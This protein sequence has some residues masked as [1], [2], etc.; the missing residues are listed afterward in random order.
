MAQ[1]YKMI[2]DAHVRVGEKTVCYIQALKDFG[3]VKSGDIGGAIETESNLS[4]DGD[5]WVYHNAKVYGYGRVSGNAKI[6]DTAEVLDYA[7]VAGDAI[8]AGN[9]KVFQRALVFDKALIDG[10]S[11][12][13][14]AAQVFGNARVIGFSRVHEDAWVYGDVLVDGYSNITRKTTI[15]PITLLGLEY[16]V[17]IM[18][19]DISIDCQTRSFDEWR[20][21]TREEAFALNGKHSLKFFNE[22]F[23]TFEF[24]VQKYRKN[25]SN[26]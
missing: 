17:T 5:C 13:Y 25:K 7:T 14:G 1:K 6:M 11:S 12:I 24:L 9:S 22:S 15:R 16:N 21:I 8:V 23:D 10:Q 26:V 2:R 20:K 18:D 4:H 3:D 19:E